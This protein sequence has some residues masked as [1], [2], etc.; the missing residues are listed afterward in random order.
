M[1]EFGAEIV[2]L[3]DPSWADRSAAIQALANN[4]LGVLDVDTPVDS[5][6]ICATLVGADLKPPMIVI[7]H[8]DSC[9][10]LP[11][12]A[13]SLRTQHRNT[14]GYV[15]IDPDAPPASDT[16]PE[17]PVFV[18]SSTEATGTSLRGW[19]VLRSEA[20]ATEQLVGLVSQLRIG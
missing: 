15:L 17:S 5:K 18:L 3:P 6:S 8:G 16:W 19:P 1:T 13:L 20:N 9:L 11:A 2:V 14:S 7:A 10:A 4:G 12:V